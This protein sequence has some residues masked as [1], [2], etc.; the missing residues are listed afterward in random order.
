MIPFLRVAVETLVR[1]VVLLAVY[2]EDK[3]NFTNFD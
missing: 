1:S 3:E 2:H